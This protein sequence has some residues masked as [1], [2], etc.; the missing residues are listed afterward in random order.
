MVRN[1]F[2]AVG[3]DAIPAWQEIALNIIKTKDYAD[4]FNWQDLAA[5]QTHLIPF[6]YGHALSQVVVPVNS[7]LSISAQNA[8]TDSD[9]TGTDIYANDYSD[10][11]RHTLTVYLEGQVSDDIFVPKRKTAFYM[12]FVYVPPMKNNK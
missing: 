2:H 9:S 3:G 11:G 8:E 10:T 7:G 5:D 12:P 6:N 4:K 1:W